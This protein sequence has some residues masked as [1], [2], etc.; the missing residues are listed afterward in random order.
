MKLNGVLKHSFTAEEYLA[1]QRELH[2]ARCDKF[3]AKRKHELA[4][5]DKV[6][7]WESLAYY[8]MQNMFVLPGSGGERMDVGTPPAWWECRTADEEYLWHLNRTGYFKTLCDL[9]LVNGEATYAEKVLSDMENWIDT[10][11]MHELQN[12]SSTPE[13]VLKIRKFYAGLTPWRSLEVGIRMFDSWN[14]AYDS[15]LFSELMT[16]ELHSKIAY[17]FYEHALVLRDMSPRYWPNANHNH[18][19]HEMLGLFE[20]ACLFPDF[21]Q[22]DAWR[23]FALHELLRCAKAQFTEDG[24][25]IEGSPHYHYCCLKMFFDFFEAARSFGVAVSQEIIV[26][27]KRAVDYMLAVLGPDGIVAPIGDSPYHPVGHHIIEYYHSSFGE[28]GATAKL[29]SIHAEDKL[30]MVSDAERA[31]ARAYAEAAGGEDNRQRQ[32]NQYFART[33]WKR[34]D[35]SFGFICHSPIFNGHAHQD[36]MS[37]V[38]YLKGDPVVVDPSYYTYRDCEERKLFKSPEYHSTLTFGGKQPYEYI[39]RWRY[40]PQKEGGIRGFYKLNGVY[41]VD[42]SHHCYDPDYHKRLCALVGDD[43]FLVADDV[44]NLTE[45]DVRIY[46]HMD[47]PTV[48]V[49]GGVAVSDRVRVLLPEDVLAETKESEKSLYTDITVPSTRL[50]LTDNSHKSRLY[51]TVFTKRDDVTDHKI[52]RVDGGVKIS[53]KQGEEEVAYLWSFSNSLK[54]CQKM[55]C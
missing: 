43:V 1:H 31:E 41:A 8:A 38:L 26:I 40:G 46:F 6:A 54:K 27:C 20:I 14:F 45:S 13:E 18:Y 37:F 39:D 53:Y 15:L 10:C 24:G 51:L 49:A 52:E 2:K 5:P 25:Q 50:V 29:F 12:E 32:I 9:Y 22:S 16:P 35:A 34:D 44:V 48:K 42:A 17:S 21:D 47:D 28:L 30:N 19:I 7:E 33:G 36:L 55:E 11:P 23:E 4:D 3:I